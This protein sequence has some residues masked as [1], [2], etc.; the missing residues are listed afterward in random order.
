MAEAEKKAE[1]K[2][3]ENGKR[4]SAKKRDMQSKKRQINNRS[5]KA[6]VNTT[7]KSF[8]KH[9]TA[10]DPAGAQERLKEVYSLLDKGVKTHV[11]KQNKAS[12]LK[13]RLSAH[14]SKVAV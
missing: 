9:L 1:E 13:S 8:E 10:K 7:I 2:K 14:L 6:K 5:Y 3:K 4:P 11:Y 12:R